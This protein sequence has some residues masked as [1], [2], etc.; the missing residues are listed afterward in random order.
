MLAHDLFVARL[1][2][3]FHVFELSFA[4][5]RID[6][7][8]EMRRH[9]AHFTAPT[10]RSSHGKRH[11]FGPDHEDRDDNDYQKLKSADIEHGSR[12]VAPLLD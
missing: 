5:H 1:P 8:A 6:P 12:A 7:G 3:L 9:F 10:T 2:L 11:V 4:H